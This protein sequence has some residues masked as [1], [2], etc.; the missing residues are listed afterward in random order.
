MKR[1][2]LGATLILFI[3]LFCFGCGKNEHEIEASI[4]DKYDYTGTWVGKTG[5]NSFSIINIYRKDER[6]KPYMYDVWIFA[7]GLTLS[8]GAQLNSGKNNLQWVSFTDVHEAEASGDGSLFMFGGTALGSSGSSWTTDGRQTMSRDGKNLIVSL[9][10]GDV[11]DS[12]VFKRE[13]DYDDLLETVD[14]LKDDIASSVK[15]TLRNDYPNAEL[16]IVDKSERPLPII[17]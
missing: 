15:K 6:E 11:T 10:S 17:K 1:N 12:I 14:D 9:N 13:D 7:C 8:P 2:I 3:A 5:V 16:V 4:E